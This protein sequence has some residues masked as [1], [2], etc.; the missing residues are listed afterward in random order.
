MLLERLYWFRRVPLRSV[1]RSARTFDAGEAR[2]RCDAQV[3]E[4]VA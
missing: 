4:E 3:I 2:T 1:P